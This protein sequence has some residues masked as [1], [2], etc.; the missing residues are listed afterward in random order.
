MSIPAVEESWARIDLWLARHAPLSH[1]RLCPPAS[2]EEIEAAERALQVD[3]P[4]D[5]VASLRCHDG[6][7]LQEG[8]PVLA[9]YGPP[10]GVADIVRSTTFLRDVGAG[11]AEVEDEEE[12]LAVF[13]RQEWLLITLGIGW[14]SSD[15]L[16]LTCRAGP[17]RGRVGRYFDEDAPSFTP[18][19]SLRH[20]LADFADALENSRMFNGRVPLAVDGV[21]LWEDEVSVIPDPV[22]PLALAAAAAE[23]EQEPPAAAAPDIVPTGPAHGGATGIVAFVRIAHTHPQPPPD[24]PDVVFVEGVTPAE[25]LC[26]LDAVPAT[27]RPRNRQRARQT[28]DSPWAAYRPLVRVG[29]VGGWAYA[30][31]ET[32]AAQFTRPE[33]LRLLSAGTRAVALTKRGPEAC[34]TVTADGAERPEAARSVQSPR[35]D[36]VRLPGGQTARH[37]GVDP[38][39]GSTAAYARLLSDLA[40]DF[41][42]TY[43]PEDDTATELSS[44]LLLPVLDDFREDECRPVS[45]VR[46]FDLAELVERTPPHR[47]RRAVTAQLVR[48]AAETRVDTYEEVTAALETIRRG[49]T[50]SL[51]H[52]DPL[53][54]RMRTLAAE[55]WVA[56]QMVQPAWR[57]D[58]GHLTQ[59]DLSAWAVRENATQALRAF[60][61]LPIPVAAA[62]ILHQ[63]MS[64][65]WRTELA[66]DLVEP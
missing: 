33:V 47:L 16:F 40:K 58:P 31:Q 28:A 13:W 1:A 45:R 41:G 37:H 8:A 23:P 42:I 21:L 57:G 38:W 36:H 20:V 25:L 24:Q 32:G 4:A 56:R 15:G 43:R 30:T 60:I 64:V 18:W 12:E 50:V 7:E 62:K 65:H 17:N 54:M 39:P 29:A 59:Q 27:V 22:S 44:A 63:R 46:G 49:K 66:A 10:S 61:Q 2:T 26:R 9:Y 35:E 6:V 11:M 52:D 53:D 19:P 48:L 51:T 5:L 34:V 55:T 3:F 14:Q